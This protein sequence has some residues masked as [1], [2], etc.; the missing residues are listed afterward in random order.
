MA[1]AATPRASTVFKLAA[2]HDVLATQQDVNDKLIRKVLAPCLKQVPQQLKMVKRAVVENGWRAIYDLV[3]SYAPTGATI[4][5][6]RGRFIRGSRPTHR[7]KVQY[8]H[9]V[10]S[11]GER[12]TI[13]D[14]K[15]PVSQ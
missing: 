1:K 10:C 8:N 3:G 13:S 12:P 15:G 2:L 9:V 6:Q 14:D 4:G 11:L 7:H 5:L